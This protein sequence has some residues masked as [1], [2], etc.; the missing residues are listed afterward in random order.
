MRAPAVVDA[1]ER[2]LAGNGLFVYPGAVAKAAI[3]LRR[4]FP[5]LVGRIMDYDTSPARSSTPG[6]ARQWHD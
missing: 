2:S 4:H 3:R 5:R 6:P 1:V